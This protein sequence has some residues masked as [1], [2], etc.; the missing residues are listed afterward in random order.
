MSGQ[1]MNARALF[2]IPHADHAIQRTGDN[3]FAVELNQRQWSQRISLGDKRYVRQG[4]RL[5]WCVLR[6]CVHIVLDRAT[7]P[8]WYDRRHPRRHTCRCSTHSEQPLYGHSTYADV[9]PSGC[10]THW[11]GD[12][13]NDRKRASSELTERLHHVNRKQQYH[14]ATPDSEP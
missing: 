1:L 4:N 11:N 5:D 3:V 14:R 12:E 2:D 9:H 8:V 6:A 10:S 13:A 7:T